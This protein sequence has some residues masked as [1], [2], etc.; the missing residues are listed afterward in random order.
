ME[1]SQVSQPEMDRNEVHL[2]QA[3]ALIDD[4]WTETY[5]EHPGWVRKRGSDPEWREVSME[6]W[7]IMRGFVLG[8]GEASLRRDRL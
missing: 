8:L 2:V 6:V 4:R 5:R 1:P 7:W 3:N